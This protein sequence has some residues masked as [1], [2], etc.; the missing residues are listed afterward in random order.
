[1]ERFLDSLLELK[2]KMLCE[3]VNV[4]K[5]AEDLFLQQNPSGVKRGGLSSGGKI[6]LGAGLLVNTPFYRKKRVDLQVTA[7]L[8]R[9]RGLLIKER[10]ISVYLKQSA[11]VI[12]QRL[13]NDGTN[14]PVIKN[15]AEFEMLEFI[16]QHIGQREQYYL[17]ADYIFIGDTVEELIALLE[18]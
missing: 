7:D 13:I 11:S 1:M 15:L 10:G 16:Q 12:Q 17:Q 18:K 8:T 6:S 4:D 14:R 5:D 9:E 3:G 2:A